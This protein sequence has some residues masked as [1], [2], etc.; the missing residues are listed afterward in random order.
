MPATAESILFEMMLEVL[1]SCFG[2]VFCM[3]IIYIVKEGA[4]DALSLRPD[5]QL[6]CHTLSET[7]QHPPDSRPE[8]APE[9]IVEKRCMLR[10]EYDWL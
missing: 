3:W 4:R 9:R 6:L 5:G 2:L 7:L 8:H 10:E 1:S